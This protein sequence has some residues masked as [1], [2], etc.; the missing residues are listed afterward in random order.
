MPES[1]DLDTAHRHFSA[2]FFNQTWT[3]L[4]VDV[5]SDEDTEVMVDLAHASR[6]HW[7]HRKDQSP[8][9]MA[10]GAWQLSRVYSIAG[11]PNEALRY[12]TESLEIA[13]SE[14]VGAFYEAYGHEAVARA[15]AS[16]GDSDTA[17]LHIKAAR[18]IL[19]AIEQPG[20]RAAVAADLD[21]ITFSR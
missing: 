12:A 19:D 20:D 15:A 14:D 5:R 11:R 2:D 16:L 13:R 17:R 10:I 21:S 7:R 8:R 3:L 9:S 6:L 4:D 1:F 18:G